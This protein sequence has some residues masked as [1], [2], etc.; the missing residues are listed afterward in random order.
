MSKNIFVGFVLLLSLSAGVAAQGVDQDCNPLPEPADCQQFVN[1]MEALDRR[2][3]RLQ[4]RSKGASP[5]AKPA[6]LRSIDRLQTERSSVHTDLV[7]C[8]R[9]HGAPQRVLAANELTARF[10]GTA[11]MRTSDRDDPGP[12]AVNINLLVRF[13]RDRCHVSITSFPELNLPTPRVNV[14]VTRQ[15]NDVGT[16]HPVSG[17]MRLPITLHFHYENPLVSDDD[18]TFNLTT[19]NSV[20]PDQQF[21]VTG[22]PLSA[23]GNIVLVGTTTFRDGHFDGKT[24]SLI[25]TANISPHP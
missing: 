21:N 8:R 9:E 22:S 23:G 5:A 1:A 12:F 18:A 3:E 24:G 6:L 15:G 2:I 17:I 19:R 10:V 25:V 14:V 20:S 16:F 7:A 11:R 4:E 13:S